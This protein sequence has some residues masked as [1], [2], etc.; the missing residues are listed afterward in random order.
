MGTKAVTLDYGW[1][2]SAQTWLPYPDTYL[3][4]GLHGQYIYVQPKDHVVVVKLSDLPT[5]S[6]GISAKIVPV[7]QQIASMV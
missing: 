7:L 4:M 1:G 6:D 3:L 2:Y 5:S